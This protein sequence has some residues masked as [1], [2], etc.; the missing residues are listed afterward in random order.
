MP[1][2]GADDQLVNADFAAH[3][4]VLVGSSFVTAPAALHLRAVPDVPDSLEATGLLSAV[5]VVLLLM[6]RGRRSTTLRQPKQLGRPRVLAGGAAKRGSSG[7]PQ[8]DGA[9]AP[10]AAICVPLSA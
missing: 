1:R 5:I 6:M 4:D 9:A 8:V 3:V 10:S 2:L 7:R